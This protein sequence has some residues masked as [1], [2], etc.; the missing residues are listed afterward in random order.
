MV[1]GVIGTNH[2]EPK[3]E[4]KMRYVANNETSKA[5]VAMYTML[6]VQV[7][8]ENDKAN[9]A[10]IAYARTLIEKSIASDSLHLHWRP[11]ESP[12]EPYHWES[13]L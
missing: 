11:V 4:L 13:E 3:G 6:H 5:L 2:V 8:F 9:Q 1:V 10:M 12:F 7:A